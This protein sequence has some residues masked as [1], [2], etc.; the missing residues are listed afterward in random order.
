MG[1][2][3]KL[4]IS[5]FFGD[6]ANSAHSGITS[7]A[8]GDTVFCGV[9]WCSG[10][11]GLPGLFFRYFGFDGEGPVDLR[12]RGNSVAVG[13]VF[14][15]GSG[16]RGERVFLPEGEYDPEDVLTLKWW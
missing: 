2:E 11:C 10:V 14:G 5:M 12:A 3:K 1:S 8:T 6:A 7:S 13:A 15:S 9:P 16:W 4:K